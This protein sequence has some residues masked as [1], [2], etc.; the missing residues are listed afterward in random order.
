M[1]GRGQS[2]QK[3]MAAMMV[4]IISYC[5]LHKI[6]FLYDRR[7][8]GL[9]TPVLPKYLRHTWFLGPWDNYNI[10]WSKKHLAP[11]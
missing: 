8:V 11:F 7:V 4:M 10:T 9:C 1:A 2:I 6:V 3:T 5:V